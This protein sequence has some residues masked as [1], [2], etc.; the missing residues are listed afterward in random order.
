M[1]RTLLHNRNTGETRQGD[2]GLF[3]EWERDP[4]VW[5]WADFDDEE[6]LSEKAHFL[7]RFGLD[8]LVV[9]DAQRERHPPKLE[10]FG[11]YFFL[12]LQGLDTNTRDINFNTIQ[13]AF[14]LNN[15]FLVTRRKAKSVSIDTVWAEVANGKLDISRGP[16]H[17][18]YQVLRRIADRYT[19]VVEGLEQRLGTMEDEMFENPRDALLEELISYGRNIKRLRRIFNYHQGLFE[20]LSRKDTPF[21]EKQGRHEFNDVFEHTERLA[22]LTAL[23]KELTDDL[24]NGYI[25]LTGHRLNQIM[26]VLTVV[27]V[28]FMPL[29]VLAGIYGMN[30]ENMPELK[31]QNAYFVLLGTMGT[32]VAGLLLLFRKIRWL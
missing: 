29:T 19:T 27:T 12:L 18:A 2:E 14:F 5:I 6:E 23:Y 26:K 4:D 30:F 24:M 1:I 11:E 10:V 15:R 8:S 31:F 16:A 28:I 32:L 20:R 22:S 21:I 9:S 7:E 25:S 3:V 13:I 17:I